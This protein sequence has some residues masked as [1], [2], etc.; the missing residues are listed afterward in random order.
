VIGENEFICTVSLPINAAID[1]CVGR[2][3]ASKDIA[4]RMAALE[5]CRRLFAV[6]ALDEYL[7]PRAKVAMILDRFEALDKLLPNE[8][9]IVRQF[10]RN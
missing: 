10:F 4:K 7:R 6:G 3:A 1:F 2:T 8:V 5:A 9:K